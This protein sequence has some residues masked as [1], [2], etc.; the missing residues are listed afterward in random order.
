MN[1]YFKGLLILCAMT[2]TGCGSDEVSDNKKNNIDTVVPT[3]DFTPEQE[4]TDP[5]TDVPA[6]PGNPVVPEE[7]DDPVVPEEPSEPVVPEEPDEPVVPEEPEQELVNFIRPWVI[8]SDQDYLSENNVSYNIEASL[9]QVDANV[10]YTENF[11]QLDNDGNKIYGFDDITFE[12]V[13]INEYFITNN[14]PDKISKL[15]ISSSSYETPVLLVLNNI[16]SPFSRTRVTFQ[17]N[18]SDITLIN[19]MAMF[20]PSITLSGD[21]SAQQG[22]QCSSVCF[23]EPNDQ[24][25][26]VYGIITGNLH[27]AMNHKSFLPEMIDFY[28][29][30][31]CAANG[32]N[33]NSDIA[34]VFYLRLGSKGHQL[35]LKVLAGP[36]SSDGTGSG[37]FPSLDGVTTSTSG[38]AA[39]WRNYITEGAANP[40]P[41]ASRTQ[42]GLFHEVAHGYGFIDPF[43]MTEDGFSVR[44]GSDFIGSGQYFTPNEVA[45]VSELKPSSIVPILVEA[46]NKRIKYK[47]MKLESEYDISTVYSRVIT[48]ERL[49]RQDRFSVENN[50]LFY[51]LELEEL[52]QKALVIQFYDDATDRVSTTREFA[53]FYYQNGITAEGSSLTFY[54]LPSPATQGE[55]YG[56]INTVCQT[57]IQGSLGATRAQ[58]LTLWS[59][60]N[61][62]PD[63]LRSTYYASSDMILNTNIAQ[64]Q[65]HYRINMKATDAFTMTIP[66]GTSNMIDS[67]DGVLCVK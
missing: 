30:D 13:G 57:Y 25:A 56:N 23:S 16:I 64:L 44:Y 28:R 36:Y 66:G 4:V 55:L 59:A 67:S 63:Q 3:P 41:Y 60:N 34:N 18:I 11:E 40:R 26:E 50:E 39:I 17:E 20:L 47:L 10:T 61:F 22:T 32:R 14:T 37:V 52:P 53:N 24:Q 1:S 6:E 29:E 54:E 8:N 58:Y 38:W 51:E 33:C 42:E 35:G 65:A 46:G 43:G 27:K 9:I 21:V 49:V 48:E 62:N 45:E 12:S 19:T 31:W 5:N 2:L 15:V 7:P